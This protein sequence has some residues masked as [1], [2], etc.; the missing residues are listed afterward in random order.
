MKYFTIVLGL[1]FAFLAL[2]PCQDKEDVATGEVFT[3]I[4]KD[5]MA[6]NQ[7]EQESCPPFCSCYCCSTVRHIT[8]KVS[9]TVFSQTVMRLYPDVAVVP[10]QEQSI[11]IWQP[12]QIA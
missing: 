11:K 5:Q 4:Q 1:Y 9:V 7:K 2:M 10:V 8:S 12:P 6:H 3:S